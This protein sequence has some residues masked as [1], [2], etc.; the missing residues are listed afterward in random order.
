MY[1]KHFS[2]QLTLDGRSEHCGMF[3]RVLPSVDSDSTRFVDTDPSIVV[4]QDGNSR[5]AFRLGGV[6]GVH[7]I[8]R[9]QSNPAPTAAGD[10]QD[11]SLYHYFEP[12]CIKY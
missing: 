6:K 8:H 3:W 10:A 2:S 9:N 5:T 11:D 12:K 1:G 7:K 4:L